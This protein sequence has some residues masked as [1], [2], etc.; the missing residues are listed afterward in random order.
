MNPLLLVDAVSA[1]GDGAAAK[2]DRYDSSMVVIEITGTFTATVTLK[3]R[4]YDGGTQFVIQAT[5]L[6]SGTAAT[7]LTAPGLYR[8]DASG[9]FEI[10]PNVAWTSGTSVTVKAVYRRG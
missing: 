7:D 5:D 10:V 8:F 2:F 6:N 3:A 4:A 1:S 9:V